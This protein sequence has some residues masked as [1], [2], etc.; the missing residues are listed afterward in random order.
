MDR[1]DRFLKDRQEFW[2]RKDNRKKSRT[3][4]HKARPGEMEIFSGKKS[5]QEEKMFNQAALDQDVGKDHERQKVGTRVKNHRFSPI[6]APSKTR[7]GKNSRIT[8]RVAPRSEEKKDFI[9]NSSFCV[10]YASIQKHMHIK[11]RQH[12]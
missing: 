12:L 5:G 10:S 3:G 11:I 7:P 1:S 4:T 9:K 8:N 6:F 2:H